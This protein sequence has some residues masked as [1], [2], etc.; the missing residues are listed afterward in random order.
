MGKKD[1]EML[2]KVLFGALPS[3][4]DDRDFTPAMATAATET[5]E[6]LPSTYRTEGKVKIL[7]Q[8]SVGS[9]VAHAIATAM[10][11]G[12][13]KAQFS[14][15]HDFSR[16]FI[17]GNR[18]DSDY[19]GEGMYPREALKSCNK[20]G[21]C[22][23]NDFPYNLSY[24]RVKALIDEASEKLHALAK[25]YKIVS[26]F[27]LRKQ[28]DI[29]RAIMNQGAVIISITVYSSFTGNCPLPSNTDKALGGHCMAMVGWDETGWI[30]QNSWGSSWGNKGYLHLPYEYPI[31]ECWGMVVNSKIPEPKKKNIFVRAW[32][33][34]KNFFKKII[35]IFKTIFRR[36]K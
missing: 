30:I 19:Q 27:R 3:P 7:N 22:L 16:G 35:L 15:A 25:E 13:Y 2:D 29:K 28:E 8:G 36:K 33:A 32:E 23:Y 31:N 1:K 6:P 20:E 34:I 21:D 17:Y 18:L 10:A 26:Y 12:E 4:D 14:T 9:C 5:E 24:P 11:Y